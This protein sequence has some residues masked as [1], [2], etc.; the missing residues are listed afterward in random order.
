MVRLWFVVKDDNGEKAS[1]TYS[2]RTDYPR[3]ETHGHLACLWEIH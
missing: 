2:S 1:M 3:Y